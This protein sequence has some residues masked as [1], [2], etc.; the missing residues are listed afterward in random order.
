MGWIGTGTP[1]NVAVKS[2]NDSAQTTVA[3]IVRLYFAYFDRVPD[4]VGLQSWTS[5]LRGGMSLN[6]ISEAFAD[7]AEFQATYGPLSDTQFVTLV[8]HNVLDRE[9][10]PGGLAYWL[11]Q[12]TSGAM[13]RGT[14]ML[15]FSKSGEFK[16]ASANEALV[17]MLYYAMLKRMPNPSGFASWVAQLDAGASPLTL[18]D[19]L[20]AAPQYHAR[21]LP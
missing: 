4:F 17:T 1:V 8:Y 21:F 11:A 13:S 2:F 15:K 16:Q 9:P 10:D 3:P 20:M 19:A 7:S 14:V 12:L 6:A 5:R 18:I